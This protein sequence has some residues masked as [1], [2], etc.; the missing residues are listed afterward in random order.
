MPKHGSAQKRLLRDL[1]ASKKAAAASTPKRSRR[2][3]YILDAALPQ[4]MRGERDRGEAYKNESLEVLNLNRLHTLQQVKGSTRTY[5]AT[6]A[7][8]ANSL[9]HEKC[10]I[11]Q[12]HN[13]DEPAIFS[14]EIMPQVCIGRTV[15]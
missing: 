5:A 13:K 14:N 6:S 1:L 10:M 8:A 15:R 11:N 2:T 9:V 3:E 12:P 7:V 4:P